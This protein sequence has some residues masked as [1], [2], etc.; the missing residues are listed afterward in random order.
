MATQVNNVTFY[1]N[2]LII[3]TSC[4]GVLSLKFNPLTNQFEKCSKWIGN[5][6]FVTIF[7][8]NVLYAVSMTYPSN[9]GWT[10]KF[11]LDISGLTYSYVMIGLT[12]SVTIFDKKY[13]TITI[14][15]LNNLLKFQHLTCKRSLKEI[16]VLIKLFG[17]SFAR[18][19]SIAGTLHQ[20]VS[21]D[22]PNS[23]NTSVQLLV[24]Y[25]SLMTI[26]FEG[27]LTL[28]YLV[29]KQYCFYFQK[30]W[31]KNC[32]RTFT[33]YQC[34]LEIAANVNKIFSPL[35]L[36]YIGFYF[37]S[38][39]VGVTIIYCSFHDQHGVLITNFEIVGL[40]LIVVK[41]I[42]IIAV[43][44]DA[45]RKVVEIDLFFQKY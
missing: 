12:F 6:K 31:D 28:F 4:V 40:I 34:L 38:V 13:E 42:V 7:F 3:F 41:F 26:L 44:T 5:T 36:W 23:I 33:E 30:N 22:R 14:A 43:P 32:E 37:V 39:L 18:L 11:I 8:L 1:L 29:I 20:I 35:F 19:A 45:M 25:F 10:N 9:F 17:E 2:K 15:T 21:N 27:R 24:D 16:P